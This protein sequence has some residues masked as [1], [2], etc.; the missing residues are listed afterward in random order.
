MLTGYWTI[1][2][3]QSFIT[4]AETQYFIE[5]MLYNFVEQMTNLKTVYPISLYNVA[6]AKK[7]MYMQ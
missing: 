7:Y 1:F 3:N 5:I 4:K 2:K 6:Y